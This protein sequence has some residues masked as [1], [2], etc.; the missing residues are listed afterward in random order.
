MIRATHERLGRTRRGQGGWRGCACVLAAGLMAGLAGGLPCS[1]RAADKPVSR[2]WVSLPLASL[3]VPA[4]PEQ[5]FKFG[6]S[7]LTVDFV[8]DSHLL[9]TFS[10][11]GLIPRLPGDPPTDDDR[12]VA[13][14]LVELPSGHVV[15][16][17][18]WHLHD[19]GRYLWRLGQGRFLVRTRNTL[20][21]LTPR[22]LEKMRD[23]LTPISF[24]QRPG[25][26]LAAVI[27]PDASLVMV[28]TLISTA[29]PKD[30]LATLQTAADTSSDEASPERPSHQVL[31]DFY[32]MQ[33]GDAEDAPFTVS[34]AGGVLSMGLLPL[35]MTQDGYLWPGDPKRD[36]WPLTFNGYG[37]K[38][39]PVGEVDSSCVPRL[40]MVSRFEY[41]AF[42]CQGSDDRVKL[43]AFGM[44][45][46]ET[47]EEGF[48]PSTGVPVFAFAPAAGRFAMSRISSAL[49]DEGT[50][51]AIPDGAAQEVRV[52]QTES[53]DL[54][55]RAPASP[56]MRDA[57]NFDLSEDGREAVV[58]N[59]DT[60]EVYQL[61]VPSARDRKDLAEAAKFAPPASEGEVDL[62]ALVVSAGRAPDEAAGNGAGAE[63]ASTGARTAAAEAAVAAAG[64]KAETASA[65]GSGGG[66]G[67]GAAAPAVAASSAAAAST[68]VVGANGG[69]N[70]ADAGPRKRPTLLL[71]G[72][73]PE[74]QGAKAKRPE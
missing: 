43:Q 64:T 69:G 52:Y 36:T 62:R 35:P 2:P 67:Q 13:A 11:R 1:A 47:W 15:A 61:P 6:L 70:E 49:P 63:S 66:A 8:D 59:R 18:D 17:S 9:V 68:P 45:G 58:I 48:G 34:G 31:V 41:V 51:T 40:Q 72:E 46:H 7:M 50:A 14:E 38:A 19:H 74:F 39:M 24:P 20:F 54:L 37:G 27:S 16:R 3:G 30:P 71:P 29:R 25:S 53:G 32:R 33:G 55:L 65:A 73:S 10:T 56:V 22:A 26:P 44:D 12:M 23:P 21:A 5:F 4:I 42:A 60:L 57:E 28:E